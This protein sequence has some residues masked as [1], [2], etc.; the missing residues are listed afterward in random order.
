[1]ETSPL[2]SGCHYFLRWPLAQFSASSDADPRDCIVS[3]VSFDVSLRLCP[4][5]WRRAVPHIS[6]HVLAQCQTHH[7][8]D[9]S[10]IACNQL[11]WGGVVRPDRLERPTF[12]F[13]ARR[14]IH[15]SYG[16]T[17][18][19]GVT[20]TPRYSL[21]KVDSN[22]QRTARELKSIPAPQARSPDFHQARDGLFRS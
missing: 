21:P 11:I 16:R 20:T 4:R 7:G 18:W 5:F 9:R 10:P 6:A 8:D 2:R 1:M 22:E 12:W 19:S 15:L 17:I 13:V 14:S 3:G